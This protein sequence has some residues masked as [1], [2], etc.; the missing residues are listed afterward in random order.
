MRTYYL[1]PLA[2]AAL[3][4]ADSAGPSSTPAPALTAIGLAHVC[5]LSDGAA[6]CWGRGNLGQLGSG[7]TTDAA[8]PTPVAGGPAF[9]SIAAGY[10]HTCGLDADGAAW[11]WGSNISGEL[12]TGTLPD[13]AC[14]AFPCQTRPAQVATSE[15]FTSL[16]AG[17]GFTCGLATSG[18]LFCWGA[19]DKGQLGTTAQADTCGP[20]R[21]SRAPIASGGPSSRFRRVTAGRSHVC[22]LTPD[23]E[24]W[25][26]GYDGLTVEG[27][28][29]HEF[30]P[31]PELNSDSIPFTA[32]SS[33]GY[34]TCG[35]TSR[36]AAWCW[37]IDAI[38]AGS[39]TLEADHPVPVAG[40]HRFQQI[41]AS[42]VTTCGLDTDGQA[43]CWGVNANGSVGT[44]PIGSL[45]LFDT[46]QAVSG[47]FR[48][49]SI[50]GGGGTFCGT[51]TD[52]AMACWGEGDAGQLL[53]GA[54]DSA[55]P[56][57]LALEN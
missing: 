20:L 24:V 4:C 19:N 14:G 11:C 6:S 51:T 29:L 5:R 31:D 10:T 28:H 45:V 25:C 41:Q 47:D 18:A 39:E 23:G 56:V 50:A 3:A 8:T 34:H 46:P 7:S 36:G 15:R 43:W 42:Q 53:N 38:G 17:N 30:S 52:G 33:G 1:L 9:S 55:T 32:I 48:F 2:F 54:G 12:G 37:G 35:L 57:S 13:E 22:A 16:A 40:N 49:S 21:C 44:E 26:W 27:I